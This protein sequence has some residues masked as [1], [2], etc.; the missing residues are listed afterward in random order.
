MSYD[1]FSGG[2]KV[3]LKCWISLCHKQSSGPSHATY[4]FRTKT[5][6]LV[7]ILGNILRL[8]TAAFPGLHKPGKFS[9]YFCFNSVFVLQL[10]VGGFYGDIWNTQQTSARLWSLNLYIIY[11]G[12]FLPPSSRF[13]QLMV[14][15]AP[16]TKTG[17]GTEW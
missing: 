12:N 6:M 16:R 3:Q 14:A 5:Q 1:I 15:G 9:K 8:S 17:H 2:A 7:K 13:L 10:E 11:V 4:R